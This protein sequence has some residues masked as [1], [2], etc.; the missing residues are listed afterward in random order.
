MTGWE[1]RILNNERGSPKMEDTKWL[2]RRD[3]DAGGS[4]LLWARSAKDESSLRL[5]TKSTANLPSQ[6]TKPTHGNIG[7]SNWKC[8]VDLLIVIPLQTTQNT[9]DTS[10][11]W[12]FGNE[13]KQIYARHNSTNNA[14]LHYRHGLLFALGTPNPWMITITTFRPFLFPPGEAP[15]L[16]N[17]QS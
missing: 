11:N 3:R 4:W 1:L 17:H 2:Y 8:N 14:F 10:F 9:S 15:L 7:L 6:I 16:G 5:L 13:F 12:T